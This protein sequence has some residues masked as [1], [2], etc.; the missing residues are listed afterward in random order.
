M[1]KYIGNWSGVI[2]NQVMDNAGTNFAMNLAVASSWFN[3][4]P[5]IDL[6]TVYATPTF[7]SGN[8]YGGGF[9]QMYGRGFTTS[10]TPTVTSFLIQAPDSWLYEFYGN[11]V[12]NANTGDS[13]GTL[14]HIAIQNPLGDRLDVYGTSNVNSYD[15]SLSRITYHLIGAGDI[16][17]KGAFIYHG[18]TDTIT[19]NLTTFGYID[20]A[21]HE[22]QLSGL[23]VPYQQLDTY[24]D[25]DSFV[26]DVMSGSDSMTGTAGADVMR[27]FAGNDTLDG[28]AG[29]DTLVGGTGNDVYVVDNIGDIVIENFD[30]GTDLVK[31]NIAT[32]NGIYSLGD[33]IENGT[34]INA[35]AFNLTGNV[36]GN[37]LTGNAAA[38]TLNGNEGAD[39]MIGGAGNDIYIVDNTGDIVTELL[40]AGIDTVQSSI[41][42]SLLDTDAAGTNGG[43]VE[44]LTLTGIANID[45]IG[46]AFNN[47]ITGNAGNN[48]LDG[49]VGN[50]SLNGGDGDDTLIGGVGNDTL[51]GGAGADSLSGDAGAD[52]LDGDAGADIMTGGDGNDIYFVDSVD[53]VLIETNG[54]AA[55]GVDIVY[56][57]VDFELGF[58]RSGGE[59]SY[60]E[61]LTLT[62]VSD[63]INAY[64]N[65]LANILT[66]NIG[67]NVLYGYAGIDTLIG[68]AGNDGYQ[69]DLKLTGTEG[70]AS[71]SVSL[72]DIIVEATATSGGYDAIQLFGTYNLTKA[73]TITLAA[74]LEAIDAQF[75]DTT[76]LNFT[77]NDVDN[78]IQGN[79]ANN[80]I[81]GRAGN[82]IL[83]GVAGNDTLDGGTGADTLY[84]GAGN[85]TY[86]IDNILDIISEEANA[87]IADTVIF[88]V[89]ASTTQTSTLTL[90]TSNQNTIILNFLTSASI[91][92]NTIENLTVTGTGN[93][94]LIGDAQ[95]NA[96]TG[97]AAN[98][99]IDGGD[100]NDTLS[101]G[102]GIDTLIGGLGDDT[103]LVDSLAEVNLINDTSGSN[104]L[105]IGL[106]Y[107]LLD[108]GA[109]TN[110][111]L[112]GT[113]AINGTGNVDAN[114]ITG[115]S[116]A[117][118]LNGN[119]GADTLIGGDGGDTY[120]VD[121][122]GD[123]IKETNALAIGGI[124]LVESLVTFDLSDNSGENIRTNIEKLTLKGTD[125]NNATGNALANT[126]TGNV[127]DNVLDGK[128]GVDILFGGAGSDTYEVD[129]KLTG[130]AGTASAVA[131]LQDSITEANT[132]AGGVDK[133][134]LYGDLDLTKAS[135]ITLALGLENLD[136]FWTNTTLLNFTGNG[137]DNDIY[138]NDAN[139]IINGGGGND[140]IKGAAGND[141]INGEAGDD[142][143]IGGEGHDTLYG[144][145]GN[146][147][148]EGGNGN[149]TYVLD[150]IKIID[151]G[152]TFAT[153][154]DTIIP[155]ISGNDT[156]VFKGAVA[157]TFYQPFYFII[158]STFENFD[159]SATGTTKI[160][161]GGS[162][163]D[164]KLIGNAAA[165]IIESLSGNDT[166]DGGLGNDT[167][168]GGDGDDTYFINVAT[169]IITELGGQGTDEVKSAVTYS[170]VDTDGAGVNGGNVENLTLAG[171]TAINATGNDLNNVL[172]GN[173][174]ANILNGGVGTDTLIGGDGGD[175]YIVDSIDDIIKETNALAIGGI[176]LVQSSIDFDLSNNVG[177]NI[178]TNIEK[179]T[180][181]GTA[182]S[183]K[184]NALANT[185]TGNAGANTLDGG[186]GID[187]LNGGL[188]SDRYIVDLVQ[189]GTTA[190]T[191]RVALQDTVTEALNAGTNDILELH[192][193]FD[194]LNA[195]T[196]T[197]GANLET[198]DASQTSSTKLN[199]TGNKLN[200]SLIGN[201]ATNILLDSTGDDT[202]DGRA[203]NDTLDGG[204]GEDRLI[205]GTENDT[206]LVD[207]IATTTGVAPAPIIITGAKLQDD[208]EEFNGTA[209][210]IDT[211]K[212][213]GSV[214]IPSATLAT[215]IAL[216]GMLAS[217]ENLDISLTGSTRLDLT[218][219]DADNKLT[220]NAANN[221]IDGALGAD[222]M[223]GGAGNDIYITDNA[224]DIVTELLNAGIDT[225]QSSVTYS[226]FDTDG[227]GLNGGNVENLTLTGIT[228]IDG[229]GN[230]LAN[231]LIGNDGNNQLIG[232]A[233]I[234]TLIGGL[235]IDLLIGGDGND[236][237]EVD[238]TNDVV[239]EDSAL[240]AG[241]VDIVRAKASF[242]LSA[243]VEN[244][245]LIGL[246]NNNINGSGNALNNIIIGDDGNNTLSGDAGND[247]LTGG[248]GNDTLIGGLGIDT[249]IGGAGNDAFVF[250]TLLNAITNKDTIQ[251]FNVAED[252]ILLDFT[253]FDTLGTNLDVIEYRS[254]AGV[255][256]AA[257]ANQHIIFNTTNGALYYDA[258]GVGGQ[259][260]IQFAT[261]TGTVGTL[262]NNSFS[263]GL[264]FNIVGTDQADTLNGTIGNDSIIGLAGNDIINGGIGADIMYGDLGDDTFYVDNVDD[265]VFEDYFYFNESN[266]LFYE[267]G[268]TNTIYSS[269]SYTADFGI[270]N[271]TLTGSDNINGYGSN[272]KINV[273][274]G[275]D[276]NNI[277]DGGVI[278]N[279]ELM[280]IEYMSPT[281]PYIFYIFDGGLDTL[282]GGKGDD[283]YIV[284][285]GET[286]I[287]N[288]NEGIDTQILSY[289]TGIPTA[290]LIDPNSEIENFILANDNVLHDYISGTNKDNLIIANNI[291]NNIYGLSGNDELKGM[292]GDD[293]LYGMSGNDI[294]W[295][296]AGNDTFVFES[297]GTS[298][299]DIVK[300]FV[301]GQDKIRVSDGTFF[302]PSL[303]SGIYTDMFV[304]GSAAQD[305][306]D[307]FIYNKST[308]DLFFDIDGNGINAQQLI[309]NFL[310][311]SN[312]LQTDFVGAL[313][314]TQSGGL[315]IVGTNNSE[316]LNGGVGNDTISGGGGFDS[317]NG[318]DG[319][320][321][322]IGGPEADA[323]HGD[324]GNDTIYGGDF[325][326]NLYGDAGDDVIYGEAR[327]DNLYGGTGNDSLFGGDDVDSI[328]PGDGND[329]VDGGDGNDGIFTSNGIDT[330]T[331]G[332]G[333]DRFIL[334]SNSASSGVDVITDFAS[335]VDVIMLRTSVFSVIGTLTGAFI[336]G[337][338]AVALDNNDYFIYD[339]S[340]GA[341]Y[342]DAD[343]NGAG[344]QEQ[345]ITLVGAPTLI[346]HDFLWL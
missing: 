313:N 295:G 120:V 247:S 146:D 162:D 181:T 79:N 135:T 337:P 220:G 31:V 147:T 144:G 240:A 17:I 265:I 2:S 154:Q 340:S 234:D 192:G 101:G 336:S 157:N 239:Q 125:N 97:N 270:G 72:E 166:L 76:L 253:I 177:E 283:T 49:L 327:M 198:L 187:I 22:Y 37:V 307:Y 105:N 304:L 298:T 39:T 189:T 163:V 26:A 6:N 230:A 278:T 326:D 124:D 62:G 286:I 5:N 156:I 90:G 88:S 95:N 205:G 116:A 174:A 29:A 261:L 215:N 305:A 303:L 103:Y 183:A 297:A 46:N 58:N 134:N 256:T 34:L 207:I 314:T 60:I 158:D 21:G 343:A 128:E 251:G 269:V 204:L 306:N 317:I 102:A 109:F 341:L 229:T 15:A 151:G 25:L 93:Y 263:L 68:G 334:T 288:A 224:G 133:L 59:R 107:T 171:T 127:G 291:A 132:V 241:G 210:G 87:D 272:L 214:V 257:T 243:N 197:L 71:A 4:T 131:S 346:E 300:D 64:G 178:R 232:L 84:G 140:N 329:L 106:T 65:S 330:L 254:G 23:S 50:D 173:A 110:L 196:L 199:L 332:G 331:G 161:I 53:D 316:Q 335:N 1:A 206:Y 310:P 287:E 246:A 108:G 168:V 63:D 143:L 54:L 222:T 70:T 290:F 104:T 258:D 8:F 285:G 137:A 167:L 188:E 126:L 296:D 19:G 42:Y 139:N 141:V 219:N 273:I 35:V 30:E 233:G 252:Q 244:L 83:F 275:N 32:A 82:D 78:S 190:A 276:G 236:T 86:I 153:I 28:A 111:T 44:N 123:V 266:G 67:R 242:T 259:A 169:D 14:N 228:N 61:N 301:S 80:L 138:A 152:N 85:D 38:N 145:V 208:I 235:G 345:L 282:I 45:G 74:G 52:S 164:N 16:E 27:G 91:E 227:A 213:R 3:S 318:N 223:L 226:L 203:G 292:G 250:D 323:I 94:N 333:G 89:N 319:D 136:A 11:I 325:L 342:Y 129:L 69:V 18:L 218:G 274:T 170:L 122:L 160:N 260:A 267:N 339:T 202:L 217:I 201:D 225:V 117:N 315:S 216:T 191:F 149:D 328:D 47:I 248:L 255:T 33:N 51:K 184:G 284:R 293:K 92:L 268:Y 165:N 66:G 245:T 195:T 113:A 40:N 98:N 321:L 150:L 311:N 294:L 99:L 281:S 221:V 112:T 119:G 312:L 279:P 55:G 43:N 36:L 130:I 237:Y 264:S 185:L 322:L 48:I 320:D 212:L 182:I 9:F 10:Y 299:S 308:G 73:S 159:F 56:S 262:T 118:I 280:T 211:L 344:V 114:I 20:S 121:S 148:L 277:L 41:T 200:N 179:L 338:D 115:N 75:T 81:N 176:D 172:T 302:I 155:D 57:S 175:T 13:S 7:A 209:D 309:A 12:V 180:L 24:I 96:L 142:W 186:A 77:G 231:L 100:G 324:N 194:H 193:N 238:E 289:N 271:L 249:L